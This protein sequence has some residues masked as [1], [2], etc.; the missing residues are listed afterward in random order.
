[1]QGKI[2]L[3][4]GG[5]RSGKSV[6]AEQYAAAQSDKVAYIAT[7]QIYDQEMQTRVALHRKRRPDTWQTF[8]APYH[9]DQILLEAATKADV[10]L[11][12]CLTIYTSNLL[13]SD[14]TPS[15]RA[16]RFQYIMEEIDKLLYFS[17]ESQATILFVTNEVGMG[18]VPENA[19]AREYRD[20]AGMVN[21]KIAACADEVYL[22]ICGLP[23]ELKKITAQISKEVYHG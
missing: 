17:R 2:L 12:D 13:L 20:I 15:N 6:F 8:E 5:T 14:S 23:V 10:I 19:L 9:A 21:Q 22:V 11:F 3:I 18:I 7:A 16:E 4:T 1:M